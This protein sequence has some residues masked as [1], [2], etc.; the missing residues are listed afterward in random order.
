M[1]GARSSKL[2]SPYPGVQIILVPRTALHH[3]S[4]GVQVIAHQACEVGIQ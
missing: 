3:A 1:P 2:T 4:R